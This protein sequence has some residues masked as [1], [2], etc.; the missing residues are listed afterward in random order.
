MALTCYTIKTGQI[1]VLFAFNLESKVSLDWKYFN[2]LFLFVGSNILW[3]PIFPKKLFSRWI[4][5]AGQYYAG[6][7]RGLHI[8]D[9]TNKIPPL[10]VTRSYS[11]DIVTWRENLI[12]PQNSGKCITEDNLTKTK[13]FSAP[14]CL[15]WPLSLMSPV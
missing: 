15:W 12:W 8:S 1:D 9:L 4:V 5:C 3:Q 10:S 11:S 7:I 6:P 14:T 2:I 13:N